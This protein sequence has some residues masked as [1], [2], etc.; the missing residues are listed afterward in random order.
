MDYV[1]ETIFMRKG[2]YIMSFNRRYVE[3][4]LQIIKELLYGQSSEHA[5]INRDVMRRA[6]HDV[7]DLLCKNLNGHQKNDK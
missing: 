2:V 3:E 5:F 7:E 4:A 6:L 1:L